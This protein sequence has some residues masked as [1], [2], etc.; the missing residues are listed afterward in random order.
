MPAWLENLVLSVMGAWKV[1]TVEE[2]EGG[3]YLI[4]IDDGQ[5]A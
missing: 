3:G 4:R 1:E 2:V 5:L